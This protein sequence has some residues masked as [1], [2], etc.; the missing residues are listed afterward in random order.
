M[1]EY[2]GISRLIDTA[3]GGAE[4]IQKAKD[5]LIG[6][7]G[8]IYGLILMDLSMK[9][10]DGYQATEVLRQ[11]Y[12]GHEQPWIV[13][14]SGHVEPA[15]IEKVWRYEIDEFAA[16]PISL[17]LLERIIGDIFKA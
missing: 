3:D 16:K 15:F 4:S 8:Y 14:C 13:A 7:G 12:Q 17:E 11:L 1:P 10:V 9:P 5:G 2:K 6:D